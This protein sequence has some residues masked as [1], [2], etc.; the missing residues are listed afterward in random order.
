MITEAQYKAAVAQHDAMEKLMNEYCRQK[1]ED[2]NSRWERFVK[3]NEFFTDDDLVYSAWARCDKC[4]AGLA[5]PKDCG[6]F[7]QWTC[8]NV[9]K[10]IGTDEGHGCYPF[11][12]YSIKSEGQPSAQGATTRPKAQPSETRAE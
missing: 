6:A 8:S 12:F 10:G 4:K 11:A 5:H 3:N 1:S 9:L 7:H 2:F